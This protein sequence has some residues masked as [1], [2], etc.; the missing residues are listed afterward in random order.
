MKIK[1]IS[2]LLLS[3]VTLFSISS[4]GRFGISIE[5]PPTNLPTTNVPTNT[6][7]TNT[8]TS[9]TTT[10]TSENNNS[11]VTTNSTTN[12]ST[13]T[14]VQSNYCTVHYIANNGSN[15]PDELITKGSKA[16]N[17]TNLV[18]ES[19]SLNTYTF[20]G[21]Y[22][23]T[24]YDTLYNFNLAVNEDLY[25]YAKWIPTPKTYTVNFYDGQTGSLIDTKTVNGGQ[26]V[27]EPTAPTKQGYDFDGWFI[28]SEMKTI[29]DLN[30]NITSSLD[31]YAKYTSNSSTNTNINITSYAGYTEGAY[32]EF[33]KISSIT[34]NS[35]KV[36]YK[37]ANNTDFVEINSE[38]IRVGNSSVRADIVG[39]EEGN[40]TI[41]VSANNESVERTITVSKDDRSGYA[42]FNNSTGVGAYNNNGTLK[43]NAV[44]VYVTD[45][46]KNTVKA[47]IKN[48]EYTGISDIITHA[49]NENIPVDIRIIGTIGA[50]TWQKNTP[51][52]SKYSEATT[53]TVKGINGNYLK[54]QDYDEYA[55]IDTY[56]FNSLDESQYSKLNGLTNKIKYDS[57]KKE[58]DSYYNMLDVKG[59]KNVTVEGI[60][61]DA[62]LF[63]W[64]F[65][66]KSDCKSIE[67]KNLT[68]DDY[69]EDACSFEGS[70]SDSSL[71]SLSAFTSTNYWIHNNTF[72]KGVNY[73]DVCSEQDKHDGDGATDFKRCAYVTVSYNHYINN[74]KTGLV[75]GGDSQMSAAL[76]FHHNFYDQCQSRLPFARQA[77]MHMYNNYY[78]KSSGNNM[79]IYSGAYAFIE[80]CYF[81]G[82]NKTFIISN[83]YFKTNDTEILDGK[84]YYDKNKQI[85]TY[86]VGT[87]ISSQKI[88]NVEIYEKR[89][90]AVKSYNNKYDNC[91]GTSGATIVSN[92][93]DAVTNGNAFDANFDTNPTNF[94]YDST[95]KCSD[96]EI[97]TN[98]DDVK[99]FVTLHAG[100][101]NLSSKYS[102]VD[103]DT[104]NAKKAELIGLLNDSLVEGGTYHSNY[105]TNK[106]KYDEA[107][108]EY[109]TLINSAKTEDKAIE[110]Y[111][112]ALAKFND[113]TK[114]SY[115]VTFVVDGT[116]YT[117]STVYDGNE[118]EYPDAPT[119]NG[120]VFAYWKDS[121]GSKYNSIP[122]SDIALYAEFTNELTY[123]SLSANSNRILAMDFNNSTANEKL[124]STM[125]KDTISLY[126]ITNNTK[127]TEGLCYGIYT[128]SAIQTIDT[129]SSGAAL[130]GITLGNKYNSG[131][132]K[133]Y[134]DLKTNGN[135]GSKWKLLS[136]F[137][138]EGNEVI[139]FGLDTNKKW[140][141]SIDGGT[142][143]NTFN[144]NVSGAANTTY[145]IY[146]QFDLD[147]GYVS[148]YMNNKLL[149]NYIKLNIKEM[150]YF[151]TMTNG[152][153]TGDGAR[154]I[155]FDNI[156]VVKE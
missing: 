30:T 96:V 136:F 77:N 55:I 110:I 137:N 145:N 35:Y 99:E 155:T 148:F 1:R 64:G 73:W 32:V 39:L 122:N 66:W 117:T 21:W 78:Y 120:Y 112:A 74:H 13:T 51:S 53:S 71:N 147:N 143:W 46:T 133:G 139:S 138:Y 113:L 150:S 85:V 63:Q 36:Y 101:G 65:T 4:C 61:T 33:D 86:D 34:N 49:T 131:I 10:T 67:V 92:R 88:G 121:N 75:G 81:E 149:I 16:T 8:S 104:L 115:T 58:F 135:I 109:T 152:T 84:T 22:S 69:T 90:P 72:E 118:I 47:T 106:D 24:N 7:D 31:I 50:A 11:T 87:T 12:T 23:D 83:E 40:Y 95:N 54:L 38:L 108:A 107:L 141:Y 52:V 102:V 114:A 37:G 60:G 105:Q 80:N 128:G 2:F 59:A 20:G 56:G 15:I 111:N 43:A 132:L 25:L 17:I 44:V 134:L 144:P 70:G 129:D 9:D 123:S 103:Q 119:K 130:M 19:D 68:F 89:T 3:A 76:T 18:K 27:T 140:A 146:F 151:Q 62:G 26:K 79:Q 41:K 42:H 154:N 153:G 97:L 93:T 116:T 156:V 91:S 6:N 5:N 127:D 100:A 29:F 48:K 94:Y 142:T 14:E 124:P 125:N 98:T 57:S 28:G 126:G 45:S 82:V